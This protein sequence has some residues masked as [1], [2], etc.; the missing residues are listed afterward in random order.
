MEIVRPRV[1]II[2][3]KYDFGTDNIVF[4][5]RQRGATYLRL[6]RDQFSEMEICLDPGA[7][8]LL[9]RFD[10]SSFEI[11]TDSLRAIYF[12]APVFLRD[13]YQPDLSPDAQFSRS[14]WAAFVRSLAIFDDVGW[15]NN[16]Q[17]TYTAEIKP[18][19]LRIAEKLGFDVPRTMVGNS[20]TYCKNLATRD[21]G[22][23][24]KTLD[25]V[26]LSFGDSDA[27]IYT[28]F[29]SSDELETSD[30]ARA[31]II[32]QQP[33]VPKTDV[34]VTVVR[35]T[36]FAVE[37]KYDDKDIDGDWRLQKKDLQYRLV[38]LPKEIEKKCVEL[39][40]RLQLTFGAIDLAL[41]DGKYYFLEI[42]PTGEWAWLMDHTGAEIDQ[43]ITDVLLAF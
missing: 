35:D 30:I 29:T 15:V 25:P 21:G 38:T 5:L 7:Q 4:R 42:N 24:V 6:N 22:I 14:Q 11:R 23:V 8:K 2:S 34:R 19:Q 37:I 10:D 33:L 1:L 16:P 40:A 43:A 36:V 17:A 20:L 31:P 18:F 28:N 12:R 9:G 13:N 3:S 32:L 41:H 26:I 39:L 27:F